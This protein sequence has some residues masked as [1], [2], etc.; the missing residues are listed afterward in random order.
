ME[1]KGSEM[2]CA[3]M[4][5]ECLE[6]VQMTELYPEWEQDVCREMTLSMTWPF[7]ESYGD[8]FRAKEL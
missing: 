7:L 6:Q 3:N 8:L 5:L 4:S 2:V 1:A